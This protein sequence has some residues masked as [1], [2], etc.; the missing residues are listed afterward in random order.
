MSIRYAAVQQL[1]ML[2]TKLGE[3]YLPLL[4]ESIQYLAELMEDSD[5]RVERATLSLVRTLENLLGQDFR[6]LLQ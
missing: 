3:A 4:P 2:Y 5:E 1:T 6:S